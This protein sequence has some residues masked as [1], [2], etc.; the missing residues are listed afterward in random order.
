M[1]FRPA[2]AALIM[3]QRSGGGSSSRAVARHVATRSTREAIRW[4]HPRRFCSQ[5]GRACDVR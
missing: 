5:A 1:T 4:S 2:A 3:T